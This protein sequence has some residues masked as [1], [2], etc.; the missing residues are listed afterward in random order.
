MMRF[1]ES[2]CSPQCYFLARISCE[3]LCGSLSSFALF[4]FLREELVLLSKKPLDV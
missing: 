1:I 2:L 3:R 4:F